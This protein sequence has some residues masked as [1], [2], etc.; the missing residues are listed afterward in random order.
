[1][2]VYLDLVF[3][4]NCMADALALYVTARL[5]GLP[6]IRRRMLIA[7]LIGGGYGLVCLLPSMEILGSIFSQTLIA[8]ILV[9]V[10]FGFRTIFLRLFFLFFILSCSMCGILMALVH[11]FASFGVPNTL[12]SMNWK[13]FFLAGGICYFLLSVVFRG[14][15]SH[16]VSGQIY[17]G[18]LC[19]KEREA[20]LNILIDTG[21]TLSDP[22]TGKPV[23]TV[24]LDATKTIW[25]KEEWEVL[26]KLN[27]KGEMACCELLAKISPGEF[28]LIPYRAV[29]VSEG[30][31]MCFSPD[32]III[33]NQSL[34]KYAVALSFTPLSAG[35]GCNALW[36]GFEE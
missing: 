32:E 22:L 1:M 27:T 18:K 14:N 34:E 8:A 26:S 7:S 20:S 29:G 21:H 9:W 25:S 19:R 30:F 4:L 31:L 12:H 35:E 11:S 15:A 10:V 2:V 36:K 28:R 6:V 33:N 13:V 23:I 17:A 3:L 16:A 5:S 24:W